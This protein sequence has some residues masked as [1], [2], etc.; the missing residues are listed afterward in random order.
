MSRI[1]ARF[2][3]LLEQLARTI[4]S[5][6][7]WNAHHWQRATF[8]LHNSLSTLAPATVSRAENMDLPLLA[9]ILNPLLCG[10]ATSVPISNGRRSR[11]RKED[12]QRGRGVKVGNP[13][14]H[15]GAA[16]LH[17]G[18]GWTAVETPEIMKE[19]DTL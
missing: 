11:A 7:L 10:G 15:R 4:R 13:E 16:E 5:P 6:Q 1:T 2:S 8:P 19:E 9:P 14:P 18:S 3:R 17:K 12:G